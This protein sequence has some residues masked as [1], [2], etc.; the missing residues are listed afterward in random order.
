MEDRMR[1]RKNVIMIAAAGVL[2]LLFA[3][4]NNPILIGDPDAGAVVVRV[5]GDKSFSIKAIPL[6]VT[7]ITVVLTNDKH[8]TLRDTA[9]YPTPGELIFAN[10]KT[11]TWEVQVYLD[12][13]SGDTLYYGEGSVEVLPGETTA[14]TVVV[15]ETGG[16]VTI[17]I[18]EGVFPPTFSP[19]AVDKDLQQVTVDILMHSSYVGTEYIRYTTNGTTPVPG[20]SSS[21]PVTLGFEETLKAV[22]FLPTTES[23]EV[24]EY[25]YELPYFTPNS[26][27]TDGFIEVTLNCE[28][29]GSTIRYTINGGDPTYEYGVVAGNATPIWLEDDPAILKAVAYRAGDP[30][31]VSD[32]VTTTYDLNL[33]ASI[34]VKEDGITGIS[35]GGS[36]TDFPYTEP[37]V[38]SDTILNFSIENEGADLDLEIYDISIGGI[39]D[40]M[41]S[42][43]LLPSYNPIIP[44]GGS[45]WFSVE[46]TPAAAVSYSG[47]VVILSDD[48]TNDPFYVTLAGQ[49]NYPPTVTFLEGMYVQGSS[50]GAVNG[51]YV[52]NT[53]TNDGQPVYAHTGGT[54]YLYY[55]SYV[56]LGGYWPYNY[57]NDYFLGDNLSFYVDPSDSTSYLFGNTYKYSDSSD[58]QRPPGESYSRV[59]DSSADAWRAISSVASAPDVSEVLD[60]L[61][62][63]PYETNT[64]Q[65]FY[66]FDDADAGDTEGAT[67]FTWYRGSNG[68][69]W[70]QV[71]QDTTATYAVQAGDAGYYIKV[72]VTPVSTDGILEGDP[73]ESTNQIYVPVP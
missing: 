45:S 36:A 27:L 31:S 65:V 10:V 29:P 41:F 28:V 49:G 16:D 17:D 21:L 57:S 56:Y 54:Y 53:F 72:E 47:E 42:V 62:G 66:D 22:V 63:W 39:D 67:I 2:L 26:P 13:T 50:D 23:S 43:E 9:A 34:V 71:Q 48:D 59:G 4:C 11:G 73:V 7:S 30:D 38:T 24:A 25:S 46:F 15:F 19:I 58:E 6:E 12:N 5:G 37:G 8:P 70:T 35:N 20:S 55:E 32:M 61:G 40:T 44:V 1:K 33:Y 60:G 69:G 52:D 51:F 3:A 68:S 18:T 14:A 64:L